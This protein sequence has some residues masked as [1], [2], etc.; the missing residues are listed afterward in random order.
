MSIQ[1]V[2]ECVLIYDTRRDYQ[3]VLLV[4]ESTV[5]RVYYLTGHNE[6]LEMGTWTPDR[7]L[8]PELRGVDAATRTEVAICA[9]RLFTARG[10]A[11]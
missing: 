3:K 6:P 7:G 5:V 2:E 8:S 9:A 11:L 1:E 4:K 10:V